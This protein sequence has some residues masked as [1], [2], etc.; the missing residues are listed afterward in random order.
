MKLFKWTHE[1]GQEF[2]T[3]TK[4]GENNF[5][6][7]FPKAQIREFNS[8]Y[9]VLHNGYGF[10]S[11]G[12]KVLE[13]FFS[14]IVKT[15]IK[16]EKNNLML[17]TGE[18]S[19]GKSYLGLGLC[20]YFDPK[21]NVDKVI[22]TPKQFFD[23][24]LNLPKNSWLLLDEPA[25]ALS[26]REWYSDINKCITW[27]VE[28]FRFR[29][30]HMVCTA[31]NPSLIDRV[32]RDFLMHFLIVMKTRGHALVYQYTPSPFNPETRTPYLGELLV[33][34]P[35]KQLRL[36]Y[37]EKRKQVQLD[38]YY[39]YSMQVQAKQQKRLTFS[40][41]YQLLSDSKDELLNKD[42][43]ISVPKIM[44]KIACGRSKAYEFKKLL[45]EE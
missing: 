30:I 13:P 8:K 29:L 28:S 38:R 6:R 12:Q 21:F 24:V 20:E 37:E 17:I 11:Q 1:N 42:L 3:I 44:L 25:Q 10:N 35:S 26:H 34:L 45:E 16:L 22:F 23:S 31:I 27:T 19:S 14:N 18:A 40:E 2:L 32:L 9:V 33:D 15:R 7:K 43:E 41:Q 39:G 5:V 36:D 4:H